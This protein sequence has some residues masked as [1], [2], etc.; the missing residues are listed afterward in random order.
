MPSLKSPVLGTIIAPL[1]TFAMYV[2]ASRDPG[3]PV[4]RPRRRSSERK[5]VCA[6][7]AA[8]SI[9]EAF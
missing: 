8:V 2:A 4:L 1:V 5:R 3:E 7:I 9:D 6:L